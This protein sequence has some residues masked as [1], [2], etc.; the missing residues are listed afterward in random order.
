[1]HIPAVD[2]RQPIADVFDSN[3]Q[4]IQ[5]NGKAKCDNWRLRVFPD[6]SHD[7]TQYNE[8]SRPLQSAVN[9]DAEPWG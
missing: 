4:A 9:G 2:D 7:K 5:L 6:T 3:Q 8:R 1:M